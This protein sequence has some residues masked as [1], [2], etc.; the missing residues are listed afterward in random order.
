MCFK[1]ENKRVLVSRAYRLHSGNYFIS[2]AV[3]NSS[4]DE[5]LMEITNTSGSL[6]VVI[7]D[8]QNNEF[9]SL[10]N[11]AT[12]VYRIKLPVGQKYK[13]II[14]TSRHTGGYKLYF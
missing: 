3:K 4:R 1:K 2:L 8:S 13:I 9:L 14:K 12:D 11:P 6:S 10:D 7:L 5:L